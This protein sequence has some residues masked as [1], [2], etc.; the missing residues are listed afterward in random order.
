MALTPSLARFGPLLEWLNLRKVRET[1]DA[2]VV[3]LAE[4]ALQGVPMALLLCNGD[5]CIMAGNAAAHSLLIGGASHAVKDAAHAW[6]GSRLAAL[7]SQ[8]LRGM[9]TSGEDSPPHWQLRT[10]DEYAGATGRVF[11][12]EATRLDGTGAAPLWLVALPETTTLRENQRQRESL[13]AVLSHDLRSPQVS[14]L[15]L[16]KM[17][18]GSGSVETTVMLGAIRREAQ[19]SLALTQLLLDLVEVPMDNIRLL[20]AMATSLVL[21]AVDQVWPRAKAAH[22][23]IES[24]L[25]GDADSSISADA[26]SLTRAIAGLLTHAVTQSP[27][28]GR[29]HVCVSSEA[30]DDQVHIAIRHE[31]AGIS[32]EHMARLCSPRQTPRSANSADLSLTVTRAV[33]RRHGGSID[34]AS[35]PG[36]GCT[37]WLALPRRPANAGDR[38]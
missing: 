17:H 16:L 12:V 35:S 28:G 38:Q 34:A 3:A 25:D 30:T 8:P 31:G 19:R 36:A 10:P 20:P 6:E 26:P 24:R 37:Y 7:L 15:S 5:G 33:M 11:R 29:V 18:D 2:Q 32:V 14:I 27:S 21:D 13:R 1:V 4:Q 9:G 22:V 23:Q